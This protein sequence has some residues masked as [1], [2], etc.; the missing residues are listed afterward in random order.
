MQDETYVLM[1]RLYQEDQILQLPGM[2]VKKILLEF[3]EAD[4][5]FTG[6]GFCLVQ[7]SFEVSIGRGAGLAAQVWQEREKGL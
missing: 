4:G 2:V 7:G 6:A 1:P 3:C 5:E